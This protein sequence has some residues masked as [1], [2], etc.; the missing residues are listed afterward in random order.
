MAKKKAQKTK[1]A[2]RTR[3]TRAAVKPLSAQ[4]HKFTRGLYGWITHTDLA[5]HDPAATRD[6]CAKVLGW[7]FKPSFSTPGGDIYLFA[8]SAKG[9]GAVRRVNPPEMP[10]S[11]PYIHV[12]DAAVAFAKAI[13]AGAEEMVSPTRVMAG[14]TIAMVRAPGGVPIGL[15]GP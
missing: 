4:T 9:G 12:A 5:S 13:E 11:I 6:W 8:Y 3:P 10:G 2:A 1:A 15:S 14:V 7:Q